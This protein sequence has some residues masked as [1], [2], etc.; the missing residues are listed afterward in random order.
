[1]FIFYG[2]KLLLSYHSFSTENTAAAPIQKMGN[3]HSTHS[4]IKSEPSYFTK[5]FKR[6]GGIPRFWMVDISRQEGRGQRP[7][8]ENKPSRR[9]PTGGTPWGRGGKRRAAPGER[10]RKPLADWAA[11]RG[12]KR[13]AA[14]RESA[15]KPL[16]TWAAQAGEGTKHRCNRIRAFVEYPKT[17][18]ALSAGPAPYRA[19]GN[20]SSVDGESTDTLVRGKPSVAGAR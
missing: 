11:R 16:A 17:G 7:A 18:T 15:P 1:M 10:V 9:H 12:R 2:S 3:I 13:R 6:K 19:A 14:S 5:L 8:P 20:L 4:C